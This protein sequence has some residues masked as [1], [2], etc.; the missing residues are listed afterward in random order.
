MLTY[1]YV[2]DVY[3]YFLDLPDPSPPETARN[4]A[5]GATERPSLARFRLVG[6]VL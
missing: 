6:K 3:P 1:A 5:I 4:P 2:G